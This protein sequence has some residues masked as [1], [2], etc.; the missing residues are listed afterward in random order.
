[1]NRIAFVTGARGFVG[2]GLVEKLI[3]QKWTVR[4]LSRPGADNKNLLASGAEVISGDITDWQSLMPGVAGA[5]VVFHLAGVTRGLYPHDFYDIN[6]G[7][8]VALAR[9]CLATLSPPGKVVILSSMAAGG[10]S[11]LNRPRTEDDPDA[12]LTPYGRSKRAGEHALIV[13][14]AGRIPVVSLRPPGIYGP[15]DKDYLEFFKMVKNHLALTIGVRDRL[16]SL[17]YV[18]DIIDAMLAVARTDHPHGRFYYV[19][20]GDLYSWKELAERTAALFGSKVMVIKLPS[21]LGTA[22]GE[23][24]EMLGRLIGKPLAYNRV[25]ALKAR[26]RAWTCQSIYL[27]KEVGFT[28]RFKLADG[29]PITIDWYKEHGWL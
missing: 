17:V 24:S 10:P 16:M 29:L 28:P 3:A 27:D 26:E 9:A 7:G 15:R 8:A 18:D 4:A 11:A 12:P 6:K 2:Q 25:R 14:L 19:S 5:R 22:I 20:D 21:P 1:M 23:I 13:L